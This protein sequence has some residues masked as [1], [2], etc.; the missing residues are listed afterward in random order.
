VTE[1]TLDYTLDNEMDTEI[2]FRAVVDSTCQG[3][4]KHNEC[5]V[6]GEDNNEDTASG[7]CSSVTP[8]A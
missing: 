6:G 4:G 3:D 7:L 8:P 5:E 2:Q 1:V